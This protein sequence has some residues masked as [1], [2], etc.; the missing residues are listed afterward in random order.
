[1]T[2][3]ARILR[4]SLVGFIVVA[5]GLAGCVSQRPNHGPEPPSTVTHPAPQMPT[6]RD[7]RAVFAT[8]ARID[9]CAVLQSAQLG[10]LQAE[11]PFTCQAAHPG[12]GR[13]EFRVQRLP[14]APRLK[15]PSLTVAA[16]KA[17]VDAVAN[18]TVWLPVSFELAIAI[19]VRDAPATTDRCVSAQTVA[20]AAATTLAD[21][22]AAR[23]DP[24]WDACAA[25]RTA[26]GTDV[27]SDTMDRC[28][29]QHSK[30]VLQFKYSTLDYPTDAWRPATIS[31]V[32]VWT[33][34]DPNPNAPSCFAEWSI[35]P[36]ASHARNGA[37][38]IAS[39]GAVDC[40]RVTPLVEPLITTLRKPPP[41]V[42]PQRPLL[43]R[44]DEP[45][46]PRPG[47]CAYADLP[48][49]AAATCASYVPVPVP[50]QTREI[51]R[52]AEADANMHCAVALDA[53]VKHLG[54]NMRPVTVS[55]TCHFVAPER[56]VRA[57]FAVSSVAVQDF[58]G[59]PGAQRIEIAGHPGYRLRPNTP[60]EDH[61]IWVA[62]S[63][64]EDRPGALQL[65]LGTGPVA[66]QPL[67]GD[68][69]AKAE[70]I[71]ADILRKYFP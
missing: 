52:A 55:N 23:A 38:L 36:A 18:C 8:L 56:L 54:G 43:Y 14:T 26:P 11:R 2:M 25:L 45:D 1:M 42:D 3:P 13:V 34:E 65:V 71:L 39:V 6:D 68:T 61:E 33:H 69:T 67:P 70:P 63:T 22:D 62:T 44:P 21:P 24:R 28:L 57:E 17:Y 19:D 30:A 51:D 40:G 4:R 29:D 50:A 49:S 64:A 35:G 58:R 7:E 59:Y 5:L 53:I 20:T 41:Q 48:E 37:Q 9:P 16:V 47:A 46:S 60:R 27:A 15:L 32:E 66:T 31:G 12:G 10:T